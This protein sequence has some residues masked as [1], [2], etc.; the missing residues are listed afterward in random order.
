MT[1]IYD[2]SSCQH[3]CEKDE[4]CKGFSYPEFNGYVH[5]CY[6]C[7]GD[8]LTAV[9]EDLIEAELEFKRRPSG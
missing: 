5:D 9:A 7:Y 4:Y 1:D 8:N 2:A 3:Q 6:L